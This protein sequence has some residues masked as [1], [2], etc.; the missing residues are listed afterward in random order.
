M[1]RRL[2]PRANPR[3]GRAGRARPNPG[4]PAR[5]GDLRRTR[6]IRP[7]AALAQRNTVPQPGPDAQ[8]VE[9]GE[10]HPRPWPASFL[11]LSDRQIRQ[12]LLLA[13]TRRTG[14][15]RNATAEGSSR[16][17]AG[18][19]SRSGARW[20]WCPWW[21]E[22]A[23]RSPPPW[24]VGHAVDPDGPEGVAGESHSDAPYPHRD[25]TAGTGGR[26]RSGND[27]LSGRDHGSRAGDRGRGSAVR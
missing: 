14:R 13:A 10:A 2:Q 5:P 22:P 26:S 16:Y 7:G 15:R 3:A 18:R 12:P 25:R 23:R 4:R 9:R 8:Q 24:A 21:S 27:R 11:H 6:P 1:V 19:V 17:H 20:R